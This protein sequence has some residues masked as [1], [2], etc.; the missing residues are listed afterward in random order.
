MRVKDLINKKDYDYISWRVALPDHFYTADE[1][2]EMYVENSK[3]AK[4]KQELHKKNL[5]ANS[6]FFGAC[7]SISG[8]LIPFD[9]DFYSPEEKIV[10]YEEWSDDTVKNGLTVVVEG[11]WES[12]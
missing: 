4:S 2:L 10:D 3:K 6:A 9:Q 12:D 11:D 5:I 8:E 7:E 1:R